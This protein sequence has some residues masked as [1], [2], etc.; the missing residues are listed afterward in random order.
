MKLKKLLFFFILL[1][2]GFFV[3]AMIA[4][5]QNTQKIHKPTI[6]GKWIVD[7]SVLPEMVDEIIA[8]IKKQDAQQAE[9]LA[10]QREFLEQ[11]LLD[12]VLEYKADNTFYIDVPNNPQSGTWKIS[13]D[14]KKI[15]RKDIQGKESISEIV[16]LTTKKMVVMNEEKKKRIY[17]AL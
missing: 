2:I 6:V 15:I 17:N 10:S 1:I 14:G 3:G 9:L 4:K 5:A 8:E 11:M 12:V 7:K 13:E 16:E